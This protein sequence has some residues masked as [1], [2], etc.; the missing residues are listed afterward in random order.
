MSRVE[1]SGEEMPEIEMSGEQMSG[2]KR[3]GKNWPQI[4]L[5]Y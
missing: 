3:P 2:H 4:K 1:M 5:T